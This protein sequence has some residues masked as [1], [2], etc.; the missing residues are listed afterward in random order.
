MNGLNK[1]MNKELRH[2]IDKWFNRNWNHY[3]NEVST[4]IAKQQMNQ[5]TQDLCIECYEAFMGKKEEQIQQMYD[6]DKILNFLLSCC[7]F[8]IKSG[9]S[10]FYMKYRKSRSKVIPE[11]YEG[12]KDPFEID[13]ISNDDRLK[14]VLKAIE[15]EQ[16]DWYYGKLLELKFLKGM[17]YKQM[18][19]IYG[20]SQ[21]SI[22]DHVQKAL[23]EVRKIC[24]Q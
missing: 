21:I 24:E 4:N 1:N 3:Y 10:P 6:D 20:F 23:E 13:D 9:S 12:L 16:I 14:C 2:N 22:R 11:Y 7:S 19:E 8:Q 15:E 5:Y 18:M 17:T